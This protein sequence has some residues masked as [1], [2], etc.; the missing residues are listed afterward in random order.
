MPYA[1]CHMPLHACMTPFARHH[2][3]RSIC[4]HVAQLRTPPHAAHTTE[5]RTHHSMRGCKRGLPQG[6]CVAQRLRLHR[7]AA[8]LSAL[9]LQQPHSRPQHDPLHLRKPQQGPL[10]NAGCHTL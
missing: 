1:R 4:S 8:P 3:T 5:A 7:P 10:C 6:C 9:V 2:C